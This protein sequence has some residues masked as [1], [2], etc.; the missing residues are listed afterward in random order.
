MG[1]AKT[2]RE[3]EVHELRNKLAGLKLDDKFTAIALMAGPPS[4]AALWNL[5]FTASFTKAAEEIFNLRQTRDVRSLYTMYETWYAQ[6]DIEQLLKA[7]PPP[8]KAADL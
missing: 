4:D 5:A 8:K 6:Q 1:V 3:G 7:G 2:S